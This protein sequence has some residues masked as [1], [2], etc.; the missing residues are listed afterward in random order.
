MNK[1]RLIALA[2]AALTNVVFNIEKQ[3]T[4]AEVPATA[5][6]PVV[7]LNKEAADKAREHFEKMWV[8]RGEFWYG[9][10]GTGGADSLMPR[11]LI[12]AKG[13]SFMIT[14][15]SLSEADKLNQVEWSGQ[16]DVSAIASRRKPLQPSATW[17][18]WQSGLEL[19][20]GDGATT[21]VLVKKAGQWQI[22]RPACEVQ[23][24]SPE[25][26]L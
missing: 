3:A 10:S 13:I 19:Y 9:I 1:S 14:A 11:S 18:D 7:G 15:E 16:V 12:Q 2:A 4:A 8:N 6:S 26:L 24:P 17:Q 25:D 20:N 5:S 22:V 21:Y 23:R